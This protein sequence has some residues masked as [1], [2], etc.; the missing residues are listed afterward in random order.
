MINICSKLH[1]NSSTK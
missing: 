1:W